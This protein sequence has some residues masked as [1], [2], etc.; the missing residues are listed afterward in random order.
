MKHIAFRKTAVFFLAAVLILSAIVISFGATGNS[1]RLEEENEDLAEK[2]EPP[3]TMMSSYEEDGSENEI[4]E[5][6]SISNWTELDDVRNDPESDYELVNDLDE[7]TDGYTGIGDDWDPIAGFE[8]TFYGNGFEI[9]DLMSDQNGLFERLEEEAVI[10]DLDLVDVDVNGGGLVGGLAEL[11]F[12][13][14]NNSS[15]TGDVTGASHTGGITGQNIGTISNSSAAADVDG[16]DYVGGLV[17]LNMEG[18]IENS[19]ATGDVTGEDSIGGLVGLNDQMFGGN[20]IAEISNSYATGNV[21]GDDYVGGLVGENRQGTINNSYATENTDGQNWVGGLVGY[22]RDAISDSYA[23]GNAEGGSLVGGL[24][25]E[26][27]GMIINS[28]ASVDVIGYSNL[29]GGLVGQNEGTISH[30]YATG[31]LEG[32]FEG[33]YISFGGLVGENR[34]TISYSY[35]TGNVGGFDR[36]GG[37]VGRN[38]YK[39]SN[40]YA[41]GEVG[42]GEDPTIGVEYGQNWVGGLVGQNEGTISYSYATGVADGEQHV[43]GLVGRNDHQISDSYAMADVEGDHEVG[44]LVGTNYY[45]ISSSYSIGEVNANGEVGG[46]VGVNHNM[47]MNSFWNE[48]TSGQDESNGGTGTTTIEMKDVA[49][50]TDL[51]NAGLDEPWDF[52]GDPNHDE[53]DEDIWNIDDEVNDGYPFFT[54]WE[55]LEYELDLNVEGEGTVTVKLA[56]EYH[57]V[58]DEETFEI[59]EYTHLTLTADTDEDWRFKEWT[60]DHLEDESEEEEILIVM[61]D[62]KS[63]TAHFEEI[64][65]YTL[66][67]GSTAGGIVVEPGE[68]EFVYDEGT[69]VD[70]EAISDGDYE[71]VEW[72]GD[73]ETIDDTKAY[74]TT[75]TIEDDHSITAEFREEVE[76]YTLTIDSTEG[77][78]VIEPGEHEFEYDHG[79]SVDLDATADDNHYFVEWTGDI[80]EMNDPEST[81]TTIE[82]L[83][84]Y[85]ITA[86]FEEVVDE[87]YLQWI[88]DLAVDGETNELEIEE[89]DEGEITAEIENIGDETGEVTLEVNGDEID[90]WDINPGTTLDIEEDYEFEDE[91][92]YEVTLSGEYVEDQSVTVDVVGNEE[93]EEED[94]PGFTTI[95]LVL[96]AVVAVAIYY[97]KKG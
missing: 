94:T 64:M 3:N 91:G 81:D 5:A 28:N 18:S 86:E 52:I 30:S 65:E 23:S 84:D 62:D 15:V 56:G 49:T 72:T 95:L 1:D 77:G 92:E 2:S 54:W 24:V 85:T 80:E 41:T 63:I 21:D 76:E 59:D 87:P 50:Y 83:D 29:I 32:H 89:G 27:E 46:L 7:D 58:E 93:D 47:V 96:A 68:D 61:D 19:Y 31:D 73:N 97:K 71:F 75:I 51:T 79:T 48:E 6:D 34:G 42:T 67:I 74:E 17:G 20:N 90:I 78:E 69:I 88:E 25:G 22:N 9:S 39:I 82:M 57:E 16:D 12:G 44:G 36:I 14:I 70:L 40:S 55:T 33:L 60:G 53:G 11:N 43:G 66:T 26:N 8:G 13:T 4:Y 37:L 35:A 45:A 38:Y 10:M